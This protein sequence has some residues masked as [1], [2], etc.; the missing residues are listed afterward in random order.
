MGLSPVSVRERE[1]AELFIV[2]LVQ[3]DYFEELYSYIDA[4]K[5]NV[6]RKVTKNLKR[7]F[8]PLKRS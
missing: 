1:V 6:C 8:Q 7:M 5:G 3:Q 4:L 2:K